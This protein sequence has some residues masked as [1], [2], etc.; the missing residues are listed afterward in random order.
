ME[1][2]TDWALI[3]DSLVNGLGEGKLNPREIYNLSLSNYS[4][5]PT[6]PI[7]ENVAVKCENWGNFCAA[8][9]F[10]LCTAYQA[11]G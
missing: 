7:T 10:H 2:F 3:L 8:K 1:I 11:R 5:E 9:N 4:I 6:L